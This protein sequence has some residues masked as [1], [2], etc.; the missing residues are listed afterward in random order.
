MLYCDNNGAINNVFHRP[1]SG[2]N[3]FLQSDYD[4][5]QVAKNLCQILPIDITATWVKGH[6]QAIQKTVQEE[7]NIQAD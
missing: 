3:S 4:L 2:I 5:I 6:S 7:I 1:L